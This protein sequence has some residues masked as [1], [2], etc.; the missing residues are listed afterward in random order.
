KHGSANQLT[1]FTHR[2]RWGSAGHP[3]A[4]II[5]PHRYAP[6][7]DIDLG[8]CISRSQPTAFVA[9]SPEISDHL[10]LNVEVTHGFQPTEAHFQQDSCKAHVPIELEPTPHGV[11]L[12]VA[13]TEL[14]Q[15]EGVWGIT[16]R[17]EEGRR[18]LVHW[19]DAKWDRLLIAPDVY[20][21]Q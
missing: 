1:P 6:R 5:R 15:R 11:S 9:G 18:R 17:D 19:S 4:Q 7:W 12:I 20:L 2:Y 13:P 10:L 8:L 3:S 21:E 16:L 14:P